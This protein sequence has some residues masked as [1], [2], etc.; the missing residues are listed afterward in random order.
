MLGFDVPMNAVPISPRLLAMPALAVLAGVAAA[1]DTVV[2]DPGHG[3]NDEGTEWRR[4]SEKELTLS[5]AQRLEEILRGK[6]IHAVLTRHCDSF[7]GL[8]ERA[9]MADLFPNSLLLSIHF[10]GSRMSDI[11]GFEIFSFRESPSSRCI[12]ASIQE[13]MVERRVG[14]NRGLLSNQDYAVLAR[15]AGC[16]VLVECGFISNKTEAARLSS[17]EGRQQIAE[18]LALGV[19]RA[20]PVINFDPPGCEIAKCEIY[21][22]KFDE[23]ERQA[24]KKVA[25]SNGWSKK[26]PKS[27]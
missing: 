3:G 8:D 25:A 10:N 7:I 16:A 27:S 13:A 18:A 15:P 2:I 5:V 1:F 14:R 20:K 11:K 23:A 19:M 4:V 21:A 17:P 26:K 9:A 22:R 12:A 24:A 6:G